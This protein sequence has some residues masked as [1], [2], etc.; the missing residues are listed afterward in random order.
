MASDPAGPFR[1]LG[2]LTRR[3]A[4]RGEP[5]GCGDANGRGNIDPAP[6][7]DVNGRVYLYVSTDFR[8]RAGAH[9][10]LAPTLSVMPLAADLIHVA[11]GRRELMHGTAGWQRAGRTETVE[12]PWPERHGGRYYLFYSGGSW[13]RNYGMGYA[14]AT[15]PTGPF[16]EGAGNPILK[17]THQVLSPG[18]GSTVIGPRGGEWMLYHA[19]LGSYTAPRRLWMDPLVWQSDGSVFVAGPTLGGVWPYP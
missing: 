10:V 5:V 6:L 13:R 17:G 15:A 2:P 8:C 7:R 18:G 9:C 14:T 4:R 19:R 1:D 12:G 11:G 3:G 16:R